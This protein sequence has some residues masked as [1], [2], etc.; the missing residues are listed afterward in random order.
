[1]ILY[2]IM[3]RSVHFCV[4]GYN[5]CILHTVKLDLENAHDGGREG[6]RGINFR[7]LKLL[8]ESM[9]AKQDELRVTISMS[10][11]EIYNEKIRDLLVST[12][13]SK[14]LEVKQGPNGT[15]PT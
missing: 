1:M 12:P 6:D 11:L 9:K 3:V 7:A 15:Y 5:V 2:L 4:D 8:F 13:S 10:L 14:K